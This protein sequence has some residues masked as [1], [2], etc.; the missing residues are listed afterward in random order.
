MEHQQSESGNVA[1]H[2]VQ[3][4]SILKKI[5][6]KSL[7]GSLL[8]ML[9]LLIGFF[10]FGTDNRLVH[11]HNKFVKVAHNEVLVEGWKVL[12]ELLQKPN[13]QDAEVLNHLKSKMLPALTEWS[14]KGA[15]ISP[16][17][18]EADFH[19]KFTSK[20]NTA[21][22]H[23]QRLIEALEEQ[24]AAKFS[25]NLEQLAPVVDSAHELVMLLQERLKKER[26]F[27]FTDS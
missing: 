15:E 10:N 7:G 4:N 6:N 21:L 5:V 3:N 25:S 23:T 19:S 13:A 16:H 24:D 17:D 1:P 18:W 26:D 14:K 12:V 2:A 22:K 27:R 8:V 20:M 9:C 11:Y